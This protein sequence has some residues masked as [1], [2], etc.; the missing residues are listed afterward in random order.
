MSRIGRRLIVMVGVIIVVAVGIAVILRFILFPTNYV[1]SNIVDFKPTQFEA[2]AGGAFFFSVGNQLKYSNEI[3]PQAPTLLN[4][5]IEK[6]LVSPDHKS[7]AVVANGALVIVTPN[8][9]AVRQVV[10]VDS[11]Y[12]EPKPIGRSF[13]R[14]DGLQ[15]S[16]D[17][18]YLY[19]IKDE[20]YQSKG[21][22]LYSDKGELWLYDI[23]AG[24]LELVLKP[25]PAD[26]YF[27]LGK[28]G[29]VFSLPTEAGDLRLRYFDGETV[30][31]I[32]EV[33]AR[34]V[35]KEQMPSA[36]SPFFSFSAQDDN[37]LFA[38]GAGLKVQQNGGPEELVIGDKSYLSFTRGEGMK[39]PF[40]CSNFYNSVFLPG[41]R[42]FMLNVQCNNYQGQ[43]LIDSET[44][45]YEQLPKDTRVYLALTTDDIPNYRISCV[46]IVVD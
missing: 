26:T 5:H 46:G 25:F 9:S 13:F 36:E 11:I 37:K 30:R 31:D 40:Y 42:Y 35:P 38:R 16:K 34:Q 12:K 23:N 24:K 44:G 27:F 1:P 8:R 22:Q 19:L 2:T 4:G 18:Q 45:R 7:I 17:S 3:N 14:D 29:V 20:Y 21:S 15:W 43:L 32:G 33:N 10:A 28:S 6:F 39:G 41:S